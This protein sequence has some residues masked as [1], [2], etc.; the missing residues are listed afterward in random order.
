[1]RVDRSKQ[2]KL[3]LVAEYT[4]SGTITSLVRIKTLSSKSGGECLLVGLR[5]ARLSLVEWDPE[6]PGI[7]TIS[8]HYYEQD[9]LQG[10]PWAPSIKDC[11]NYLS[12]DP[13]SRCAAFK[14]GAR[15]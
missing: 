2:S 8:I 9:E 12:A 10:S 6:R 13:G 4:L 1:M 7:S 11:V 15:N 14:F 5:D 3:I